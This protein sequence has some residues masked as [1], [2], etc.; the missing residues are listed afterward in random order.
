MGSLMCIPGGLHHQLSLTNRHI[1]TIY[2]A[3]FEDPNFT[4]SVG[5]SVGD[6]DY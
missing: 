6:G 1:A 5:W 2:N 4:K 3:K